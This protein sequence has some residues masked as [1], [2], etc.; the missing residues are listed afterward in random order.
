MHERPL[1]P[2]LQ[3][4][5]PQLTSVLSIT[6][7]I[8]GLVLSAGTLVVIWWLFALASGPEAFATASSFMS[9]LWG[10][11]LLLGLAFCTFYHLLNGIRHL[12]WD[13]GHALELGPAYATGWTVVVLSLIATAGFGFVLFGGA[14]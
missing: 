6:H 9:G 3:I 4:Y 7:R 13:T 11:L 5:K 14:A 8:T 10:R 12:I 1:S 2:H